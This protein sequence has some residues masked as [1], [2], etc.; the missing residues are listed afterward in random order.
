M[1]CSRRSR[2][3]TQGFGLTER[4]RGDWNSYDQFY[5][6]MLKKDPESRKV[7]LRD[8]HVPAL[9]SIFRNPELAKAYALMA[10]DGPKAFYN[11]PDRPGDRR[12]HE[13]AAAGTGRCP[14]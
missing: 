8:G 10:K 7:F 2:R 13:C 4:I 5:V 1:C 12:P 6:D 14:T 9:Y 11:G 3:P